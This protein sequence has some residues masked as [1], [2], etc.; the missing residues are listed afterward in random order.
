MASYEILANK[1]N[2]LE[3]AWQNHTGQEVEDFITRKLTENQDN[4]DIVSKHDIKNIT[5]ENNLLTLI[6]ENGETVSTAVTVE[7]PTY[8]YGIYIYGIMLDND[9]NKIYT[10]VNENLIMQYTSS[11]NVKVGIAMYAIASTSFSVSNRPG[12]FDVKIQFGSQN[13]IFNVSNIKY[14]D[15]IIDSGEGFVSGVVG[16]TEEIISKIAW[17]DVTKLFTKAQSNSKITA[18]VI[19]DTTKTSTLNLNITN[20]VITLS[21]SGEY[22][23]DSNQALFS[24]TGASGNYYL[25]IYNN[26]GSKQTT[27]GGSLIYNDLQPGLNQLTVRAVNSEN[28]SICSD[29]LYLD[30]ICTQNYNNTTIAINGVRENIENNGVATL[31]E[32]IVYSPKREEIELTT[33]LESEIDV[34]NPQPTQVMKHEIIEASS[35]KEDSYNTSYKKYIEISSNNRT[36]YLLIKIND[37]FYDFYSVNNDRIYRSSFKVMTVEQIDKKLAY[38][39]EIIPTYNFDQIQGY[40]NNIFITDVYASNTNPSTII[41]TLES[42]D[43]WKEENGRTIFKVSAQDTPILKTPINLGLTTTCSIEMGIKTYNISNKNKPILTIGN[44]QLKPTQFCWNTEDSDLFAARNSQ[45]REGV[46]THIMITV[47]KGWTV[48]KSDIYYPNYLPGDYQTKYDQLSNS[49]MLNLVR[50]YINGIIDREINLT[51]TEIQS[52]TSAT[53]QINPTT[54]DIDFYLFRVYNNVALNFNQVQQNYISFLSTKSDKLKYY[55]NN[56]ILGENGEISFTKCYNKYNTLVYVFPKGGRFPNRSW[57][58]EDGNAEEDIDKKLATTLFV[59]YSDPI[60]NKQYGGRLTHGQVKGQGSSAMRYLIWNVTYALNKLKYK[61]GDE[62]K[63]IKSTFTPYS[64]MDVDTNKF[65]EDASKTESAYIMPPYSDQKDTTPYKYTK[66]VGKVNF[67][68][69]MQSHKIGA[70]K[71]FDDAYKAVFTSLPS[72][73]RKAV[74]EEPFLYFY[75]E[76]D[77]EYDSSQEGYNNPEKSPIINL[78]LS[79]LFENNDKIKFMGFQTWGPGKG[80]DECSGYSDYTPEYLMMEGGENTDPSVN[81]RVPWQALQRGSGTLGTA[82][83]KLDLVPTISYEDSL[84]EPWS[85]LLIEDESIVYDTRGA[86]DIDYG[87]EEIEPEEAGLNNYFIFNPDVHESVKKFREF[88][89]FVYVN[90]FNLNITSDKSPNESGTWDTHKKYVV[91][92]NTFNINPTGHKAGDMYRYNE[93]SREWVCAGVSYD[94]NNNTWTRANIYDLTGISVG[95]IDMA[96]DELKTIFEQGISKYISVDDIAFHQAFI[97]FLSG[98]D[99]RAKNTYFQIIGKILKDNPDYDGTNEEVIDSGKGDYLIRLIGDDLDT[100][101]V[102]DNNGL[103]S[104]PYNLLEASYDPNM[105]SHWGDAQNSFFYM[106]DQ[107]FETDI[108]TY[109]TKILD[110]TQ[111]DRKDI[112]NNNSYFYRTFFK[113]QNEDFPPVAYN[114][115]AKIYYENAQSIK[116]SK[117]LSYY[118]NNN[119][120]PI[121]QSHGSCLQCE[122]QFLKERLDFLAGYAKTCL[123]TEFVTASSAGTGD[124]LKLKLEF[125]PYQDFYPTYKWESIQYLGELENSD[126]D[127]IKYQAKSGKTYNVELSPGG[128]AIN[129]GL[130]QTDLF[131]TLNITGLKRTR[132]DADFDRNTELYIDNNNLTV[133]KDFFESNYPQLNI[134]Q[135]ISNLP[136]LEN[137]SL[138]NINISTILDCSS[139]LKLKTIDL[140]GSQVPQVILP[141]SGNLTNVILPSSITELSIYNNPGL[142]SVQIVSST[143]DANGNNIIKEDLSNLKTVY[144]DCS[145]C[146][147]FNVEQFCEKLTLVSSLE[148]ITLVNAN[149]LKMTE[150]TILTLSGKKCRFT[151]SFMIVNDINSENPQTTAI[152][153][154]TKEQLVNKFGIITNSFNET[155]IQY[156]SK[157]IYDSYVSCQERIN[158]YLSDGESKASFSNA[159]GLTISDGNNIMILEETNPYNSDIIGRLDINYS[160]QSNSGVSSIDSKT[161]IITV[162]GTSTTEDI[163]T[164]NITTSNGALTPLK[165]ILVCSWV[166]PQIGDFAYADGTFSSAY[167]KSKTLVGM[168]YDKK[169]TGSGDAETGTAYII[170]KEYSCDEELYSGVNF[171]GENQNSTN[172]VAKEIFKL[173]TL[174]NNL[175]LLNYSSISNMTTIKNVSL[176]ILPGY[177]NTISNLSKTGKEDTL[178]YIDH[179][180]M[181]LTILKTKTTN[182]DQYFNT[183]SNEI[184]NIEKLLQL[185][186]KLAQ[187][188]Y[189]STLD[190]SSTNDY[191]LNEKEYNKTILYPYFYSMYLYEPNVS[192]EE[193]NSLKDAYKKNNWY[194]PSQAELAKVLYQRGLSESNNFTNQI[195]KENSALN[196]ITNANAIFAIAKSKMGDD[197]P[198]SWINLSKNEDNIITNV[199]STETDNYSYVFYQGSSSIEGRW[200]NGQPGYEILGNNWNY[201][202]Y[203]REDIWRLNKHKGVPFTQYEYAKPTN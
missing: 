54:S 77:Y 85:N 142:E 154:N 123:G 112:L 31:Y 11:R 4:I 143:K 192:E 203:A 149:N 110:V 78:N 202:V 118:G 55:D 72:G 63:K 147:N 197:F 25:E 67:A 27:S 22:I 90:N 141:Q 20:E 64:Q 139:Y 174:V 188:N 26:G 126:F 15:C 95:Y 16:S 162:T 199:N 42:S 148:E 117:V 58:G 81:F 96:I 87:C 7:T 177:S 84:N 24:L 83:Y 23:V 146:G 50:V 184:E 137:L 79:D 180:R 114:H 198:Q 115:H 89:D 131:K 49:T 196:N 45:F 53:L 98:T 135:F 94:L 46:E 40:N 41:S 107:C 172:S 21:Y 1:I 52:L 3:E 170:G 136:V 48:S 124:S 60:K 103:Q 18:T 2:N 121:E 37:S 80:D 168:V 62:E 92:G 191:T 201:N 13:S 152:K 164:I 86:W 28:T 132:I 101:L 108:V 159:F 134:A 113:V 70:C 125:E 179:V 36:M 130:Y 156:N 32:L 165:C 69:S 186:D 51:D 99:N 190:T 189:L 33:Y 57:G 75:W 34:I 97:K 127:C 111:L 182:Y 140:T 155:Y 6:K 150:S 153:F 175:G 17:V 47:Q 173:Q 66:M 166:P 9:P 106:F 82:T 158:L 157:I 151:G 181:F 178:K 129:Q 91:T 8:S 194:A 116:N 104:K 160:L 176:P 195:L 102:T 68:S 105:K 161:G 19:N 44:F 120:E 167:N 30:I 163:I 100:I 14:E 145:K 187:D 171:N 109:L 59:N 61:V 93:V 74:H 200:L 56:D 73:G 122:A 35:Y 185:Q 138:K 10:S 76:S 65:K 38:Y 5:Y 133:Y 43:G 12:P 144:I 183:S 128:T 119:I 193:I 39:N 29:Y 169:S 88:Y 71:L